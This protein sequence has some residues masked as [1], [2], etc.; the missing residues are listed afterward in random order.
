[1]IVVDESICYWVAARTQ[2]S[3]IPGSG[4]GI[5]WVIN[6]ETLSGCLFDN[7]NGNSVHVALAGVPGKRWLSREFL[8]FIFYYA[9]E[10]LK[11]K[12]VIGLV[13]STNFEAIK[14]N[15]HIGFIREATL[16]DAGI[17]GDLHI[18]T[19]TKSQSRFLERGKNGKSIRTSNT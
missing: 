11:V 15:E 4:Q 17:N 9:F 1:M 19:I 16:R 7:F 13:D 5:G 14:F 6:G 3:Y 8:W 18:Y 12:K 2:G 10:Q